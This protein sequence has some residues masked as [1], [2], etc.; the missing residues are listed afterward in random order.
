[1]SR[2]AGLSP[3]AHE[4]RATSARPRRGVARRHEAALIVIG[5]A[6]GSDGARATPLE[7]A[8]HCGARDARERARG[9]WAGGG[10]APQPEP[11]ALRPALEGGTNIRVIQALLGHRC[12]ST[13]LLYTHVARTYVNA[14]ASPLDR[15]LRTPKETTATE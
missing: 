3:R 10:G 14:T 4:L 11:A 9:R 15:L 1:V 5:V 2:A 8:A 6:A 7:R 13:T 12:L